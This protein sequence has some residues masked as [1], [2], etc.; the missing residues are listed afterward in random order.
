MLLAAM[1]SDTFVLVSRYRGIMRSPSTMRIIFICLLLIAPLE[2]LE[3]AP[4]EAFLEEFKDPTDGDFDLSYWL[5]EKKGFLTIFVPIT[6][7]AVGFGLAFAGIFLHKSI[8]DLE[9]EA[10]RSETGKHKPP[11]ITVVGGLG[12]EN[13]T[14]GGGGGHL[15]VWADDRLRYLGGLAGASVNLKFYGI[16]DELGDDGL[17]YNLKGAGTIQELNARLGSSDFFLGGRYTFVRVRSRFD[18]DTDI[19]VVGKREFTSN[20]GGL[21]I[22]LTY[23]DRDNIF[24]PNRGLNAKLRFTYYDEAFGGDFRYHLLEVFCIGYLPVHPRL[25]MGLRLEGRFSSG[26]V[27]F[28]ALP[29]LDMRGVPLMKYQGEDTALVEAEARRNVYGRWSVV[30]FA[31]A[32]KVNGDLNNLRNT[33]TVYT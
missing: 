26:D 24:T 18:L 21:G 7:P 27:P 29:Y 8:A 13:G 5:A 11:S 9:A 33:P 28:Y 32:G 20:H 17:K 19:P 14:W 3:P 10:R 6:E 23:D 15:G 31:G 1:K 12:T 4:A 2:V 25:V 22:A 30:G 16:G